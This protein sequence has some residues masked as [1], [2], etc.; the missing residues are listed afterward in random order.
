MEMQ[1]LKNSFIN[2]GLESP[3]SANKNLKFAKK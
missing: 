2:R 1:T 3:K